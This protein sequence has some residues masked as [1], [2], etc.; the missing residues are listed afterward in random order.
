MYRLQPYNRFLSPF[1]TIMFCLIV[2]R[3]EIYP[4][5]SDI[6]LDLLFNIRGTAETSQSIVIVGVD[7]HSLEKLG[8]WPF[9]RRVHGRL[10]GKLKQAKAI[11][12]DIL[13]DRPAAG[14]EYFRRVVSESPPVSVAIAGDYNGRMIFPSPSLG[15]KIK[16]G[17][18]ETI[19]GTAGR[20]KQ[21]VLKPPHGF[22]VLALSVY[23]EDAVSSWG[24]LFEPRIINFYGPEFTFL[25]V[26]YA[27]V[28]S[29]EIKPEFF[30]DRYVLVGARARALGDVHLIPFSRKYPLPGVEVQATI[31]NNLLEESFLQP[32]SWLNYLYILVIFFI[33]LVVWPGGRVRRNLLV[34][35]FCGGIIS[36][37]AIAGFHG[38]LFID[39]SIPLFVLLTAYTL[40]LV[41]QGFW[42]AQELVAEIKWLE[43]QLK[44]GVEQVYETLPTVFQKKKE[45]SGGYWSGGLRNHLF[46]MQESIR[47]LTLQHHF[48][49]HLLSKET[50]PLALWE[51][52]S[53]EMVLTNTSF[54]SFWYDISGNKATLPGFEE[55]LSFLSEKQPEDEKNE[56]LQLDALL[57]H[58]DR[59]VDIDLIQ[60]GWK[61]Y[62]R[63]LLHGVDNPVSCFHGILASFTDVTEIKELER[64]KGEVMNIVSHELK[65]P[66][67][68]ILGYGEMLTST[69]E[70]DEKT[71]AEEIC[72]QSR[73]L[74][75]MIEDF[76]DIAR[77]E[78]GRY[79]INRFP[80]DMLSVVYDAKSAIEHMA[81]T[82][83]IDLVVKV[84]PRVT[85]ILGDEPLLTQAIL[86]L[87]DNAVKFSPKKSRVV[88]SMSEQEEHLILSVRDEG[89]GVA[90]ADRKRI[91]Q[92]FSRGEVQPEEK[93]FGLGLSFVK[94]VVDGHGGSIEVVSGKGGGAEF[95]MILPK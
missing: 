48:V 22:P 54:T 5:L 33:A 3:T 68:T 83:D 52:G 41:V 65:L 78:S 19:L 21:V 8:A 6:A 80:L 69:L 42:V 93:G 56:I 46:V 38:G 23:G 1:L 90:F 51:K 2:G 13:F 63:V 61:K 39:P 27:D 95:V 53:G 84:P 60:G 70:N 58:G 82:K 92:K 31:L 7:E 85:P 45:Q 17:H 40:H 9:D 64:L 75:K 74:G 26:S 43:K 29:G 49:N 25:Y 34:L 91:F 20:V 35:L 15:S 36:V 87:L 76:L 24:N 4:W 18:I 47:A 30:K 16:K 89:P 28:L 62:C 94:Q 57:E 44:E 55:F 37:V 32:L 12:F 79:K 73:R 81:D 10:L 86:N 14:D 50:P 11:G 67:T 59:V 77:V 88:F 71:Y 72:S 66:L